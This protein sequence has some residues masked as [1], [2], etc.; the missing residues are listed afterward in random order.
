MGI[1]KQMLQQLRWSRKNPWESEEKAELAGSVLAFLMRRPPIELGTTVL[2]TLLCGW[3]TT[4]RYANPVVR[5]HLCGAL[6][7]DRQADY[8]ACLVWSDW[9]SGRLHLHVQGDEGDAHRL[10]LRVVGQDGTASLKAAV[11]LD[12]ARS[13]HPMRGGTVV[14]KRRAGFLT[15]GSKN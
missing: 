4:A 3:C 11:A 6:E 13:S 1:A 12:C 10:Y 2:R 15:R 7:A 14:K 8:F 5:C 9:A